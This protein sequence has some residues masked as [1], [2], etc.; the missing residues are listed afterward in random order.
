MESLFYNFVKKIFM[1][2]SYFL[3]VIKYLNFFQKK[4]SGQPYSMSKSQE[5]E[6]NIADASN[7]HDDSLSDHNSND[8]NSQES[9]N[10][11]SS[12]NEPPEPIMT[13]DTKYSSTSTNSNEPKT[14]EKYVPNNNKFKI[15]KRGEIELKGKG[16][17]VTYLI[18]PQ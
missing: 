6:D 1:K 13:N 18:N 9:I 15:E 5:S 8:D 11:N 7:D 4:S 2:I 14:Y 3:L 16:K 10:L 17:Q 12:L